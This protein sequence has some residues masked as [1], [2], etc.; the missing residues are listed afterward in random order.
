MLHIFDT[1]I[2]SS[3]VRSHYDGS[4]TIRFS[5]G[6]NDLGGFPLLLDFR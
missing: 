3:K 1:V 5:L 6:H 2:P 4:S